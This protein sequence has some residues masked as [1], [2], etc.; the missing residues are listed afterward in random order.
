MGLWHAGGSRRGGGLW[1]ADG[2]GGEGMGCRHLINKL[3]MHQDRVGAPLMNLDMM[4]SCVS[5]V[6]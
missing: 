4:Q 5:W 3:C 6:G 2:S 1:H